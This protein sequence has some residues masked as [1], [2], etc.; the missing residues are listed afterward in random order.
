MFVVYT[1]SFPTLSGKGLGGVLSGTRKGTEV[2]FELPDV[3]PTSGKRLVGG[4]AERP[5]T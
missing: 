4:G 3:F 2:Q 5:L 1:K